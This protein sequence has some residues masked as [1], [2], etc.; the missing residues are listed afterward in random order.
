MKA[1]TSLCLFYR[2]FVE[3]ARFLMIYNNRFSDGRSDQDG[4][5]TGG[6]SEGQRDPVLRLETHHFRGARGKN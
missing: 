5:A 6:R 3:N 2:D 4:D 1:S